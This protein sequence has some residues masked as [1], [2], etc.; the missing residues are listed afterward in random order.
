MRLG[1]KRKQKAS[2]Q[3]SKNSKIRSE[4]SKERLKREKKKDNLL[5]RYIDDLLCIILKGIISIDV[6]GCD[7]YQE[8]YKHRRCLKNGNVSTI[9]HSK[10]STEIIEKLRVILS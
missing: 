4:K 3:E 2:S 6:G 9:I 8:S 5:N 7:V 1:K 10:K